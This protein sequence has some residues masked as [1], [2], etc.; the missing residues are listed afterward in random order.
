MT[1]HAI[2]AGLLLATAVPAT[3]ALST[4]GAATR[5]AYLA[6][7]CVDAVVRPVS[8]TPCHQLRRQ[9]V[10]LHWKRWGGRT[11]TATGW[12]SRNT[13]VPDCPSGGTDLDRVRVTAD[14]LRR[15]PDGLRR[16]TRVS[17]VPEVPGAIRSRVANVPCP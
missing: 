11:A 5:P 7:H 14:R 1:R 8:V 6:A 3:G 12:L 10:G 9:L 15:C 16:Y 4:A 17:Y 13:C 2:L